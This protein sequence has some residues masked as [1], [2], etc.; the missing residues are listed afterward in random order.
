MK[1]GKTEIWNNEEIWTR[2]KHGM[3]K[4]GTGILWKEKS[5]ETMDNLRNAKENGGEQEI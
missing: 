3:M 1:E 5:K 4:R 2:K